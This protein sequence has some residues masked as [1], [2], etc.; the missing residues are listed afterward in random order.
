MVASLGLTITDG[1]GLKAQSG[2][3]TITANRKHHDILNYLGRI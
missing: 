2:S 3:F 1:T